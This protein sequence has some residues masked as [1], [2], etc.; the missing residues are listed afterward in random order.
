M[1]NQTCTTCEAKD[2]LH[3]VVDRSPGSPSNRGRSLP[4]IEV[5]A[6]PTAAADDVDPEGGPVI[7]QCIWGV[8]S[9]V[10]STSLGMNLLI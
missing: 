10:F 2:F 7:D 6:L 5:P 3:V 9:C 1:G 4:A 8:Y